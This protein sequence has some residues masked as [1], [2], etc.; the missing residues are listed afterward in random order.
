MM[1]MTYRQTETNIQP[2]YLWVCLS[3]AQ[4]GPIYVK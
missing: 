4:N 3:V 2:Y 1:M